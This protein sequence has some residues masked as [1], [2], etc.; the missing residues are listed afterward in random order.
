MECHSL[1][2]YDYQSRTS[3]GSASQIT[4]ELMQRQVKEISTTEL[5]EI[6]MQNFLALDAIAYIR[7]VCVYRRFKNI[8]EALRSYS[9]NS[10][11]KMMHEI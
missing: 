11:Q 6:V 2:A 3:L 4:T 8:E 9:V 5:G 10:R 1:Q 7:F